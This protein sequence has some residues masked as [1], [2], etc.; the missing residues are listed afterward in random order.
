MALISGWLRANSTAWVLFRIP[1]Y[2]KKIGLVTL[3]INSQLPI[4][5]I[6]TQLVVTGI[7]F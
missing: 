2:T 1:T 6:T 7:L 5:Y 4:S 3:K